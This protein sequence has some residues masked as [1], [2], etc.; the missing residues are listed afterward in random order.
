M[1]HCDLHSGPMSHTNELVYGQVIGLLEF[2]T[3]T[4]LVVMEPTCSRD[5]D[6]AVGLKRFGEWVG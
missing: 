1:W 2:D 6:V 3:G 4:K 5:R